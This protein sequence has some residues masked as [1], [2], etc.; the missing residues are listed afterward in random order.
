MGLKSKG[1]MAEIRKRIEQVKQR[2][3]NATFNALSK[4]GEEAISLAKSIPPEVGFKDVTGNL[5][6]SIGYS[7]YF[8]GEQR[9]S[10]FEGAGEGT[11]E[12][13]NVSDE[14]IKDYP[15][16]WVLIVVAGMSYAAAVESRGR[17]VL[18]S[19][20]NLVWLQMPSAMAKLENL[21]KRAK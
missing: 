1:D 6:A 14:I 17:D 16:G 5:R 4:L 15:T 7:I 13:Q 2:F 8:N 21:V 19:A 20:E 9:F 3:N 12:G 18:S 11:Q 10:F